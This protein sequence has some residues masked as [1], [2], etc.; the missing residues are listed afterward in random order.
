MRGAHLSNF[1]IF[2]SAERRL[3][4]DVND[5]DEMLPGPWQRDVKRLAASLEAAGRDN[6]FAGE[7]CRQ[8]VVATAAAYWQVV[9]R[10]V[11]IYGELYG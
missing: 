1:G 10:G 3:V 5:F 6:G 4:F 8:I 7:G 11:R 2:G 9:P